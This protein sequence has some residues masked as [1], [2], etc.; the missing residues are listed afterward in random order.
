MSKYT[1]VIDTLFDQKSSVNRDAGFPN[2]VRQTYIQTDIA[3][4]GL[5]RPTG[6]SAD[7]KLDEARLGSRRKK[8]ESLFYSVM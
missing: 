2:V 8:K 5:N 7:F 3:T 1:N 6:L 4:Y